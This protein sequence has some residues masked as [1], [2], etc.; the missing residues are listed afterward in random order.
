MTLPIESGGQYLL[1][2]SC[3]GREEG[4]EEVDKGLPLW[5]G[6]RKG[7]DLDAVGPVTR[8][9]KGEAFDA[10]DIQKLGKEKLEICSLCRVVGTRTKRR[11]ID[12]INGGN[13]KKT[14]TGGESQQK[15]GGARE[16][17]EGIPN[18]SA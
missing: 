15:P 7:K 12:R 10:A 9:K 5:G 17:T 2:G 14:K 1:P 3:S 16:K 6:N 8:P 13:V 4:V 11:S 18:R